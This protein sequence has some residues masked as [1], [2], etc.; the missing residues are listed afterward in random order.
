MD[1]EQ[2]LE[3]IE[4]KLYQ[5]QLTAGMALGLAL[6]ASVFMFVHLMSN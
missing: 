2:R 6:T 3:A 1:I 5:A 4:K